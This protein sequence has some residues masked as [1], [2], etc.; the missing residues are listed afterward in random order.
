MF[1]F[2]SSLGNNAIL[3]FDTGGLHNTKNKVIAM[4]VVLLLPLSLSF[5]MSVLLMSMGSQRALAKSIR[6]TV[7][8]EKQATVENY[9]P[10]VSLTIHSSY[11]PTVQTVFRKN[12]PSLSTPMAVM[13]PAAQ[14]KTDP[15]NPKSD[16]NGTTGRDGLYSRRCLQ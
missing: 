15:H 13:R 14:E 5:M 12:Q 4:P 1:G 3:T 6:E 9:A 11:L 10:T 8:I 7:V 16:F 2:C